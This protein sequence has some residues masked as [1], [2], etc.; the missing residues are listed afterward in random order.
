M[1]GAHEQPVR[2]RLRLRFEWEAG[3]SRSGRPVITGYLYND[4]GRAA[5]N[6]RLLVGTLDCSGR[7]VDRAYGFVHGIEPVFGRSYFV[8]PLKTAGAGY[9]I[10]VTS[11]E[12]R[13]G[14]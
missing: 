5:N 8:V 1:G 7:V 6:V 3:Q 2:H 10:T 13:D 4:Y 9:R 11:Y 14:Q 12:W